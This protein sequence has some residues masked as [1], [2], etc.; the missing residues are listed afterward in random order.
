MSQIPQSMRLG[1]RGDFSSSSRRDEPVNVESLVSN[2]R[3]A[4][5][6]EAILLRLAELDEG[7]LHVVSVGPLSDWLVNSG[8]LPTTSHRP[9][10]ESPRPGSVRS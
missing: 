8:P 4:T 10:P 2:L 1:R 7:Q 6:A 3:V 5:F 9:N